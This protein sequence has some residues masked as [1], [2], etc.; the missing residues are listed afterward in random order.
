MMKIAQIDLFNGNGYEG[1]GRLGLE[2]GKGAP[3]DSSTI[4]AQFI[5]SSIG[6]ITLIA[7]IWFVFIFITGAIGIIT[8]GGD[9]N[10]NEAARKKISSGVI[11]LVVTVLGLL[12]I[13][14]IGAVIGFGDIL[15]F[16][17]MFNLLIIK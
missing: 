12:I 16:G 2:Q 11:G 15:D 6:L 7:V 4:F 14:F 13:R 3:G 17:T 8:S 1:F 5:S 10:S 9:K